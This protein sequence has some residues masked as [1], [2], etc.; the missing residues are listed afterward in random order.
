MSGCYHIEVVA[1]GLD[2]TARD[3]LFDRIAD[4]AHD[5]DE[6]V[7]VSGGLPNSGECDCVTT[8]PTEVT[9]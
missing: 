6:Q 5:L 2:D 9:S 3:A 7:T 8:D 4:A 1:Y